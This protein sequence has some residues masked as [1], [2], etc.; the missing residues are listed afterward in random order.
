MN[1]G[2]IQVTATIID[3]KAIANRLKETLK[4]EVA[5]LTEAGEKPGLAVVL[6][7][8]DPASQVYVRNKEKSC[9]ELGIHSQVYRLPEETT[10]D[11][12]LDLIRRAE[13][14]R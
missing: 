10:E 12:L 11:K 9:E 2:E 5:A 1:M 3:G 7:G 6:V 13:C 14:Q 4:G 8:I